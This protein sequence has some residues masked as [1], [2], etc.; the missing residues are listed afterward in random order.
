MLGVN[1]WSGTYFQAGTYWE[2]SIFGGTLIY[3]GK[4]YLGSSNIRLAEHSY[5][6]KGAYLGDIEV[7]SR[8]TEKLSK[9]GPTVAG[10]PPGCFIPQG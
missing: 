3:G 8:G 6:I 7:L 1:G 2:F 4:P 9:T 5:T 10:T